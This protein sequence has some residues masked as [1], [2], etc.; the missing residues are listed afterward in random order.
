M[1]S[2]TRSTL[3]VPVRGSAA[4]WDYGTA[5]V[6][7]PGTSEVLLTPPSAASRS[8][9]LRLDVATGELVA[10][11]GMP[12][13][14]RDVLVPRTGRNRRWWVLGTYGVG[15]VDPSDPT[16]RDVLRT[17]IGK[18][19]NRLVDLGDH[20]AIAS[21]LSTMVVL[22]P[23][24]GGPPV[25]RLRLPRPGRAVDLGDGLV[26]VFSPRSGAAYDVDTARLKVVGKH[27]IPAGKGDRVAGGSVVYLVGERGRPRTLTSLDPVDLTARTVGRFAGTEAVEVLGAGQDGSLVVTTMT[28]FSVLDA[29]SGAVLATHEEARGLVGAGM[30]TGTSTVVLATREQPV[31]TLALVSW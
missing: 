2:L 14:M 9:W 18:Y 11:S 20:L 15:R 3:Q 29:A 26:R 22:V 21:D 31:G 12:G 5:I 16:V 1:P 23:V 8:P 13:P 30:V 27:D 25:G 7:V 24:E 28:G 6:Q 17:G 10:G 19:P 4:H